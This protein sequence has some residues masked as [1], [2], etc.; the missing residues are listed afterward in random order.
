MEVN[1]FRFFK[2]LINVSSTEFI[3]G[4]IRSLFLFLIPLTFYY[5]NRYCQVLTLPILSS[6]AC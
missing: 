2:Y 6:N 5:Q 4:T 3:N 1:S